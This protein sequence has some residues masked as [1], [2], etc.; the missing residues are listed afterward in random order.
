MYNYVDQDNLQEPTQS[1]SSLNRTYKDSVFRKLFNNKENALNLYNAL[2]GQNLSKDADLR[3]TT[4]EDVIYKTRKNDISFLLENVF[5]I[6]FEHQSTINENMSIRDLIYYTATIQKMFKNK[7]FYDEEKIFIPRPEF[8]MLYNGLKEMPDY[9]ELHLSDNFAGEG[10]INL[11]LTVK[12]YNINEGRN[13]E[14][15]ERCEV[16][17]QYSRFVSAVREAARRGEITDPELKQ[18]FQQCIDQGILPDFLKEYG[19][20]GINML[21]E[22]LTQ[23]EAVEMARDGGM[24]I[25]FKKGAA[26]MKKRIN[27]LNKILIQ[28]KR[29]EDLERTTTDED[30]Q[31]QLFEEFGL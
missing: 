31:Q 9:S 26:E 7:K 15:M 13:P 24:R 25:G 3:F 23:E 20:E 5:I 28:A 21:F 16:L 22:E 29:F 6:L 10:E 4:L 17:S 27:E 1:D 14:I 8:I 18:L 2:T 19:T 11:Q 30:F 12:V